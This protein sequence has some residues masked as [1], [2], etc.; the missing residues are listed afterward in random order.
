MEGVIC[1]QN[2]SYSP[3]D[4]EPNSS[5]CA[6][7]QHSDIARYVLKETPNFL[8][9]TDHAPLVEGHLLI[10]PRCH[11]TCY[12][13]V[14]TELDTELFVLKQEVQ[15]FLAQY[16][17][18]V[19]FWEHGIFRQT[20]FHAHL[21]CFPF[22]TIEYDHTLELHGAVVHSQED[23]RT[24]HATRGQYF[25]MEQADTALL[26]VPEIDRYLQIIKGIFAQAAARRGYTGWRSPEQRQLEGIPLIE[27]T[28]ASWRAF[29]H[30]RRQDH[31]SR[32]TTT[33]T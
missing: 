27:A 11:Y 31:H 17:A 18:P 24:W 14:P 2:G 21:H 9:V 20:V 5:Y 33:C 1:M 32:R 3:F 7:C 30:H 28:A 8:I 19:V 15:K 12:G 13:D 16:Y 4:A 25:Y 10:I 23:I 29:Q 6:F 22:G 26:F